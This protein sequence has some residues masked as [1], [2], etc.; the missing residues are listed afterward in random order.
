MVAAIVTVWCAILAEFP[1][2]AVGISIERERL[3]TRRKRCSKNAQ[4]DNSIRSCADLGLQ[5][6]VGSR[7]FKDFGDYYCTTSPK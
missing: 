7:T 3:K 4:K 5:S 6:T 2:M 1:S